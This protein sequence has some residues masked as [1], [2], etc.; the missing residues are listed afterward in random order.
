VAAITVAIM[1]VPQAMA[2]AYLAGMPPIYGL[3]G[4]L[5]PLVIYGLFGTSRKMSI[6]PVANSS[7]LVL[8]GV[9]QLAIP[10]TP[11]YIELV[12]LAGF[13]IGLLQ[14]ALGLLKM[15]FLV[16]FL[17]Y[18][19]LVGFTSAAALIIVISQLKD[20]LGF[21]V[22]HFE[23]TIDTL[24][25]VFQHLPE[26]NWVSILVCFCSIIVMILLRRWHK[27]IPGALVVVIV[28]ILLTWGMQLQLLGLQIITEVP[29]G[30]PNIQMP[31]FTLEKA[32]LLV[33]LLLTMPI[34][35]IVESIGIAKKLESGE[36]KSEVQPNQELFALGLSKVGGA[37]F[38][39]LPTSCS[40]TRSA[41][42]NEA[43][44]KTGMSSIITAIFMAF[45]LLFL[46]PLF[47]YLP[48]AVLAAIILLSVRSLF[49]FKE[50][51]HL[52]RT[53]HRDLF[54]MLVTFIVTLAV[55][56][57]EGIV[58]GVVLSLASVLYR[59]STPHVAVLGN[60]KGSNVY[61]NIERFEKT[62]DL[63]EILILRF[64]SMLYFANASHFKEKIKALVK[65]KGPDLEVVI[66]DA[67]TINDMDSTGLHAL[68]EMFTYLHSKKI[69]FYLSGVIGPVRDFL[70]KSKFMEKLGAD[71]QFLRIHDA[72]LFHQ[73]EDQVEIRA[74]SKDAIQT[75]EEGR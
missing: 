54:M 4:G 23:H 51:T 35:G 11:E 33:P 38:Q 74:R 29:Q 40:F 60:L 31:A 30:L 5:L 32:L 57:E 34:I 45:T 1:L 13:M 59:S 70:Y 47:Y 25:Y 22:P 53:H 68:E 41:V 65:E 14:M 49:D 66:L 20:L 26:S 17:S 69:K 27:S 21:P 46:T 2:Y 72:V 67:S 52:W 10:G 36:D 15:G 6:G 56:V 48:K 7:L 8:S 55:G 24:R 58:T 18:P 71:H 63:K 64:D 3:Y 12:I 62:D 50:A 16:N 28:A 44:A 73:S 42:N 43:G 61:R 39:A 19:V 9:G 75:N 37:L